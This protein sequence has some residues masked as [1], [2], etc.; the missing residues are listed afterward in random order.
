MKVTVF[1]LLAL[2]IGFLFVRSVDYTEHLNFTS[3]QGEHATAVLK[4]YQEKNLTLIG[5]P[6]T[7]VEYKGR[8]IFLGPAY[9]YMLLVFLLLANF[10]PIVSSYIFTIFAGLMIIPLY[11]GI[12]L[13]INK[14]AALIICLLYAFL[15][16]Y[17]DYSRFHWNPT[18]QFA[19]LPILFLL[20]GLY[21]Q[22]RSKWLFLGIFFWLGVLLQFH[23]QFFL[24]VLGI[25]AY[26]F[27][28]QKENWKKIIWVVLGLVLGLSP[29]ILF[30]VKNEFYNANTVLLYL[31]HLDD[32]VMVGGWQIPHYYLS[33]SLVA[34]VFI[35]LL[36]PWVINKVLTRLNISKKQK[37]LVQSDKV[38]YIGAGCLA[39]VLFVWAALVHFPKP[40]QSFWSFAANWNYAG[41]VKAYEIIKKENLQHYNVANLSYYD[42]RA[43][44]IKYLMKKDGVQIDFDDYNTNRYLFV[45]FKNGQDIDRSSYEVAIMH[46]SKEVKR[47]K[48][49]DHYNLYL[50]ERD[51]SPSGQTNTTE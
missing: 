42:T 4:L 17:I 37:L 11:F 3:D 45:V 24:V 18:Y 22:Y 35:A 21:K 36:S 23:Y 2:F 31:Q 19:L 33:F 9:Y 6:I 48:L 28:V 50:L 15:P 26:Y 39:L 30:E 7:S 8:H 12:K 34:F 49:N 29:L 32:V 5:S 16:Y 27:I 40:A 38:F 20:M 47:W 46:P 44:V 41:E 43:A 1:L 25:V 10:D 14:R 13:L 51:A